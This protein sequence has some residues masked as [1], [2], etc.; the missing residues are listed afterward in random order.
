MEKILTKKWKSP[1][2][3]L[4]LGVYDNQLCLCEWVIN[5][6]QDSVNIRRLT[7]HLCCECEEGESVLLDESISKLNEYFIGE[8]K[9]FDIP[10]VLFGTPFQMRV[11]NEMIKIPYASTISYSELARRIGNPKS[12]RAV[13]SA[14]HKNAISIIVPCHRVVGCN[15]KLVGYAGGLE[16]KKNLLNLESELNGN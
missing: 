13:G 16:I 7:C 3:E 14:A 9:Y 4:L 15:N 2:G 1:I 5:D 8:R 11:W 6:I 12:M 10:T